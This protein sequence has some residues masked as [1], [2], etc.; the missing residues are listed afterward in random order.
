VLVDAAEEL[1]IVADGNP[2]VTA[3]RQDHGVRVDRVGRRRHQGGV[4]RSEERQAEV[5]ETFLRPDRGD[6]LM[7]RIELD[8]VV[9]LVVLGHSRRR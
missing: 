4:A 1:L 7:L 2:H 3:T 6:E 8:G 5:A 9:R